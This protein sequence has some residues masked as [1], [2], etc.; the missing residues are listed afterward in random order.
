MVLEHGITIGGKTLREHLEVTNIATAW[1]AL[2]QW[3][4]SS[5]PLTETVITNLN[6]LTMQGILED[7]AGR[8]PVFIRGSRHVPP[9]PLR[10]SDSMTDFVTKF[11]R[12]PDS[13]HPI[14]FAAQAHIRLAAIHPFVDGN[15][16]VGSSSGEW[17]FVA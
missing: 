4:R 13:L 16:R 15:G 3:V 7:D 11:A 2:D 17:L 12:R 6:R 1:R 10:V 5:D 8:V 9:N 14:I